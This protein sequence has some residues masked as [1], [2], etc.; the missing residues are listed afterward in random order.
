MKTKMKR[1]ACLLVV[2]ALVPGL[3]SGLAEELQTVG[4]G[5]PLILADDLDLIAD[6]GNAGVFSNDANGDIAEKKE[7]PK[8][9]PERKLSAKEI[10]AAEALNG[11]VTELTPKTGTFEY[12][13]KT[14]YDLIDGTPEEKREVMKTISQKDLFYKYLTKIVDGSDLFYSVWLPVATATLLGGGY[15]NYYRVDDYWS[16]DNFKDAFLHWDSAWCNRKASPVYF[17]NLGFMMHEAVK[18]KKYEYAT[19]FQE[20]G[21]YMK[22]SVKD[23]SDYIYKGLKGDLA[24]YDHILDKWKAPDYKGDILFVPFTEVIHRGFSYDESSAHMGY[25]WDSFAV[26]FYDFRLKPMTDYV[27][28]GVDNAGHYYYNFDEHSDETVVLSK[29]GSAEEQT[30]SGTRK[31]SETT[32]VSTTLSTSRTLSFT[33]GGNISYT[34]GWGRDVGPFSK[35]LTIGFN[36]SSTQSET[37]TESRTTGTSTTHEDSWTITGKTKPSTQA[38][39]TLSSST[40]TGAVAYSC[41]VEFQY[42]VAILSL[43]GDYSG[44]LPNRTVNVTH[45]GTCR[46]FGEK[47]GD[48]MADLADRLRNPN[49]D[50]FHLD[51]SQNG[52]YFF[53]KDNV[54]VNRLYSSVGGTN[55]F[56]VRQTVTTASMLTPLNPLNKTQVP[57]D[58]VTHVIKY[59][60]NRPEQNRIAL[61]TLPVEGIAVLKGQN[62]AEIE[63][64]Y[65]GFSPAKGQWKM[66][67][68]KGNVIKSTDCAAIE[69]TPVGAFLVAKKYSDTPIYLKYFINDNTYPKDP[70]SDKQKYLK[71]S[72]LSASAMIEVYIYDDMDGGKSGDRVIYLEKKGKN[73]ETVVYVGDEVTIVPVFA[74]NMGWKVTGMKSSNRKVAEV[75]KDGDVKLH[76]KGK[77][78]ITV[79]AKNGRKKVTAR[80][81]LIVTDPGVPDSISIDQGDTLILGLNERGVQLTVSAL[82]VDKAS[83]AVKWKSSNKTV[84]KVN[85]NGVLT[86]VKKG[87]A[88][89]IATSTLN[90]KARAI[91]NVT[92]VPVKQED[93]EALTVE[94]EVPTVELE[95]PGMELEIPT[96]EFEVSIQEK[97][98]DTAQVED[99]DESELLVSESIEEAVEL[100]TVELNPT[101]Y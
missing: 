41:P 66:T 53:N 97:S 32:T 23:H 101:E 9:S 89:I 62:N 11:K 4:Q 90:K 34:Y 46:V 48:A 84:V 99:D 20:V 91:I 87:K 100:G 30:L 45:A 59:L 75:L 42:K 16:P 3:I 85:A 55:T 94:L 70:L 27:Q 65:Y 43:C 92:V 78:I 49:T 54:Y 28:T 33:E 39:Y 69:T 57:A 60:K 7:A 74:D 10:K 15:N 17:T 21:E 36:F 8:D 79:T 22:Q 68:E 76:R 72:D 71:N 63:V 24:A 67:D 98:K 44:A 25:A 13:G 73:P 6:E 52:Y 47:N 2:L 95:L 14:Y 31:D 96:V 81:K 37:T 18:G 82:P 56:T 77:A 51:F 38:I 12:D 50:N 86:P 93:N 26:C 1:L 40:S 83:N 35:N 58:Q 80:V 88:K 61:A 5:V 19:D 64:P 29:N